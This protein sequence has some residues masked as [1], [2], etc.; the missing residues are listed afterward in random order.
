MLANT[1][2]FD[3]LKVLDL[4]AGTG[5]I[6]F[7][8]SSRGA[9]DVTAVEL[10][11]RHVSFIKVVSEKLGLDGYRIIKSD[12]FRFVERCRE[13]FDIV[14]ADPPYDHA[15]LKTIPD[16]V[17]SKDIIVPGGMLILEHGKDNTFGS[18][19]NFIDKRVYGSV[20][21]SMFQKDDAETA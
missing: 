8:F 1:W 10:E 16:L 9:G 4:F 3:G 5:S 11:A 13:K 15:D 6:G 17:F 18:H 19:P 14:F 21:F 20:N 7:E 2:D 12:A